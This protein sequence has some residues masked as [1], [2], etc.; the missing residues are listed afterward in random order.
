[1]SE[2]PGNRGKITLSFMAIDVII[3]EISYANN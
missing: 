3:F 2:I 1:M